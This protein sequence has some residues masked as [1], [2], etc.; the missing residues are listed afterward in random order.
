MGPPQSVMELTT[1]TLSKDAKHVHVTPSDPLF[2]WYI[3]TIV[4]LIILGAV[5]SGLTLG[6]MGLDSVSAHDR[7]AYL[8]GTCLSSG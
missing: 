1:M 8:P 2:V 4:V 7:V 3:V 6:L 5:F